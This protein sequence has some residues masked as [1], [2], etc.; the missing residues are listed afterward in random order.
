LD[1]GG[2]VVVDKSLKE[3]QADKRNSPPF[4]LPLPKA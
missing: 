2:N 3:N 1:L 4:L